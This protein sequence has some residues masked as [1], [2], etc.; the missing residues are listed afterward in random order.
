MIAAVPSRAPTALDEVPSW[1]R[2]FVTRAWAPVDAA[3]L[4]VFRFLLGALVV[5]AVV[6]FWAKGGV[7]DAFVVPTHF[8]AYEGLEFVRPLPGR[9]MYVVYAALAVASASLAVGFRA[10]TS[11]ALACLLFTYAHGCDKTNY[12]NH[13]YLVSLLLGLAAVLPLDAA[14]AIDRRPSGAHV[15][16]WVL[17]LV[18]FQIGLVYFYG[19]VGKLETDWLLHAMPL[20]IWLAANGD[21]PLLGPIL[22]WPETAYVMSWAGA[23]FDLSIALLLT[24]RRTRPFG[25]ACVVSFHVVTAR[26]FQIGMFPWV[27]IAL[28]LVFF[29]PSWPRRLL[30][31]RWIGPA[32]EPRAPRL[33]PW[34]LAL[35]VAWAVFHVLYPLRSHLYPGDVLWTEDGYRFSWRVMLIEKAGSAEFTATDPRTGASRE[36]RARAFLTPFQVKMMSTQ[37][38]MIRAF[39]RMVADDAER[40]GAPRPRVTADVVVALNGRPPARLVDPSVDLAAEPARLGGTPWLLPSPR[41]SAP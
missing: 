27:M 17:W 38:D 3:S 29:A 19:G 34:S 9:G 28:T 30:P 26:L 32:G 18:R 4:G 14:L 8:F 36:V 37:P 24:Q 1:S 41:R 21:F 39:A 10:R 23:A 6:R 11:A 22:R 33:P 12:L 7:D 25:Y 20:R 31:A 2:R 13:Y 15:P 5:V 16:A 35:A 40:R